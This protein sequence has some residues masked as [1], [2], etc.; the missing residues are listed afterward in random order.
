MSA[1]SDEQLIPGEVMLLPGGFKVVNLPTYDDLLRDVGRAALAYD[2]LMQK[3]TN[4]AGYEALVCELGGV[5]LA[6]HEFTGKLAAQSGYHDA[7]VAAQAHPDHPKLPV[8]PVPDD[9][10]GAP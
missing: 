10:A 9:Q 3:Y 7:V 5:L 2:H 1:P 6:Y 4:V 8:I